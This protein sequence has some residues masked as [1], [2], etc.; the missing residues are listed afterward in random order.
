MMAVYQ[1]PR[2]LIEHI[3]YHPA[4]PETATRL[5]SSIQQTLSSKSPFLSPFLRFFYYNIS[6]WLQD[7]SY[8]SEKLYQLLRIRIRPRD[9]RDYEGEVVS[10]DMIRHYDYLRDYER[11]VV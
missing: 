10:W 2:I 4:T 9:H 11:E 3:W 8:I 5:Q 1:E 6:R 7:F